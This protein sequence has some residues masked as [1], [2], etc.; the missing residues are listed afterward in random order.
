M[1][2]STQF[3]KLKSIVTSVA[4]ALAASV[5]GSAAQPPS[6]VWV[7]FALMSYHECV[8]V[9]IPAQKLDELV[10]QVGEKTKAKKLHDVQ[11]F[12]QRRTTTQKNEEGV[13]YSGIIADVDVKPEGGIRS[14]I[15][16]SGL[17]IP[18]LIAETARGHRVYFV[19]ESP[20]SE[21]EHTR[22]ARLLFVAI[23]GVDPSNINNPAQANR[24]P[25]CW[26][27]TPEG[28]KDLKFRATLTNPVPASIADLFGVF[29]Y[30]LERILCGSRHLSGDQR[31]TLEGHLEDAGITLP[32]AGGS[33]LTDRCPLSQHPKSCV[34]YN[35][36]DDGAVSAYCLAEHDGVAGRRWGELALYQH[37]IGGP[38][39]EGGQVSMDDLLIV[40]A[41]ASYI[42]YKCAIEFEGECYRDALIS[43]AVDVWLHW[44]AFRKYLEIAERLRALAQKQG[45][46]DEEIPGVSLGP[47]L[48]LYRTRLE[49]IDGTGV[50]PVFFD[51][52]KNELRLLLHGNVSRRVTFG[53]K[54]VL[55]EK[56][57]QHELASI[58]ATEIISMVQTTKGQKP[59][60]S[61]VVSAFPIFALDSHLNKAL[62]GIPAHL[63][64]LGIPR[65]RLFGAP[66]AFVPN[67]EW[68][69]DPETRT[70][71]AQLSP[72]LPPPTAANE[73][74][75]REI[76]RALADAGKDRS[77]IADVEGD[78]A[79]TKLFI[80]W[81]RTGRIP[82]AT[83]RDA[84]A[85][86]MLLAAPLV[87]HL[88]PGAL[89]IIWPT[90]GTGSGKGFTTDMCELIWLKVGNGNARVAFDF[91][92]IGEEERRKS[93]E[94]AADALYAR[95]QEGGK[96]LD[97]GA[98]LR[99][100]TQRTLS[101]RGLHKDEVEILNTFFWV[102]SSVEPPIAMQE[103]DRRCVYIRTQAAPNQ[104]NN[105]QDVVPLAGALLSS[106]KA[107]VEARGK[108]NLL[109]FRN[110]TKRP[111]GQVVLADL[112]GVT[113][114]PI[115]GR[116]LD[117]L[118]GAM[119]AFAQENKNEGEEFRKRAVGY[120]TDREAKLFPSHSL[121]TL[122]GYMR[123]VPQYQ[124]ICGGRKTADAVKALLD[125]EVDY[126]EV[127]NGK[128][129]HLRVEI[130]GVP[131]AM[132]LVKDETRFILVDENEF[133]K[134]TRITV[135]NSAA[136]PP[137]ET[138]KP[139]AKAQPTR[140]ADDRAGIS[141]DDAELL[142]NG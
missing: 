141:F 67:E 33:V 2:M 71:D 101:V 52:F 87:R 133:I 109:A 89:G 86:V 134:R 77:L 66:E 112:F 17:P 124:H 79:T 106:L 60:S 142:G 57:H 95:N 31:A 34:Y 55:N 68:S 83:D 5:A 114:D 69:I 53:G 103:L 15:A 13:V 6:M 121:G 132:K 16:R 116:P 108:D 30:R 11:H 107:H 63:K 98:L 73:I 36:G 91:L 128:R 29:P 54:K 88:F 18:N 64:V 47:L 43:A 78:C 50:A 45:L 72:P 85:A 62:A 26:K 140:A 65:I 40:P 129:P 111:R 125:R 105:E 99:V 59:K 113:L 94:M 58:A 41:S 1:T 7:S 42:R 139:P 81:N 93:F 19:L 35:R 135:V 38:A 136:A 61:L 130:E 120:K 12:L 117:D 37:Y 102:V 9:Q 110:T 46:K 104:I 82:Y 100:S 76:D 96:D 115:K 80:T 48:H 138:I 27:T 51:V 123:Q 119:R 49:G 70:I 131:F 74:L 25:T 32:D 28:V 23:P 137:A 44:S 84:R 4:K 126:A 21:E 56:E 118:W 3:G 22:L 39:L 24:L 92:G 90:G 20:I 127:R 10:N 75:E 122:V 8:P 14:A 97:I